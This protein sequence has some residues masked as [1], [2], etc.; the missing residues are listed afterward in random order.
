MKPLLSIVIL[1]RNSMNVIQRLVA[2]LE[3]QDFPHAV[4]YIFMD[5]ASTDGTREYLESLELDPRRVEHV[6]IGEFSHS[7]TR[8]RAA[9]LAAGDMVAFFTDDIIPQG[10]DFLAA[11]TQPVREGRAP[12]AYGVW[13]IDPATSDPVDAWLHNSWYR[14]VIQ[15]VEPVSRFCWDFFTPELRRRLCNFDNCASCVRRDL[16]LEVRFPDVPYGEDMLFAK[17][18]VL[19][20]HRVALAANARFVHWHKVSFTYMMKR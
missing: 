8:M 11:L 4:E 3:R 7:G 17:R 15:L 16:L 18:L 2:A 10:S 19:G 6:S 5:N 14:D 13:Q 9:S 20:G 12:A 1:T